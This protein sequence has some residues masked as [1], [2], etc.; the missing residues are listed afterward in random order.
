MHEDNQ[1]VVVVLSHLTFRSQ[2]MMD[3]LRKLLELINTNNISIRARYIRS[4]ANVW[5]DRLNHETDKDDWQLNPRVFTYLDSLWGPYS[6]DRFATQGNK[7][8]LCYNACW[9]DP[10]AEAVDS[11]HCPTDYGL[12]KPTGATPRGRSCSTSSESYANQAPERQSSHRIGPSN[13]G[14]NY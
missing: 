6:I 4:A 7:Q 9:R 12:R 1:V 13:S 5:A 8:L 10:T 3:E 2:A 14:T 11:Q